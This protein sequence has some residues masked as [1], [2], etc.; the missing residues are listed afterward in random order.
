[1]LKGFLFRLSCCQV[2]SRVPDFLFQQKIREGK[3]AA[4]QT[5]RNTLEETGG[6]AGETM[7]FSE[8]AL[9]CSESRRGGFS[10]SSHPVNPK[11]CLGREQQGGWDGE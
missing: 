7:A 10:L 1:M 8:V 5:N 11:P 3:F 2:S 4:D 9:G 6:E